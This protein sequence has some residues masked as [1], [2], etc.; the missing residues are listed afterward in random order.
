LGSDLFEFIWSGDLTIQENE[1]SGGNGESRQN[2]AQAIQSR[3][4]CKQTPGDKPDGK[5]KQANILCEFFYGRFP[6]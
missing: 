3:D 6:F 1:N 4:E 2:H 5:K